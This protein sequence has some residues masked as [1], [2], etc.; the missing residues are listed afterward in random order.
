M[1]QFYI[2]CEGE[3]GNFTLFTLYATIPYT[4]RLDED[5]FD[6]VNKCG[7]INVL[8]KRQVWMSIFHIITF[9][10]SKFMDT[11]VLDLRKIKNCCD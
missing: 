11:G 6:I 4:H 5:K 1:I 2:P 9:E 7:H 3:G 8:S 10:K